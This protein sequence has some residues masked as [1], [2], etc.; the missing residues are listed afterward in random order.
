MFDEGRG[1]WL[2]TDEAKVT[3]FTKFPPH[4]DVMV[5]YCDRVLAKQ[6]HM[7]HIHYIQR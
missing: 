1:T 4:T 5:V 2:G 6:S 7:F 3:R